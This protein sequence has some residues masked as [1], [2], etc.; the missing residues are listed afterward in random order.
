MFPFRFYIFLADAF[1]QNDIPVRTE[2][3]SMEQLELRVFAQ[4]P[5]CGMMILPAT[6]SEPM[7][8]NPCIGHGHRS[9]IRGAAYCPMCIRPRICQRGQMLISPNILSPAFD[10][11]VSE[12]EVTTSGI[13]SR[14]GGYNFWG[15][16]VDVGG[17][18]PKLGS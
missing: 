13:W 7:H 5:N 18:D 11:K 6:A 3:A 14:P 12:A 2:S 17:R 10:F 4:E 16:R 9:L 1:V 15:E 8:L